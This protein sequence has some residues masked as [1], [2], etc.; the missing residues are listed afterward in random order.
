M[1]LRAAISFKR[2]MPELARQSRRLT[3]YYA[4]AISWVNTSG[5]LARGGGPS[6]KAQHLEKFG[7][8]R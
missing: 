7:A 8:P 6:A 5:I 4:V 1:P 3:D 2:P